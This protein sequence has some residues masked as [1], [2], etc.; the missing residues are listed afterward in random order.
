MPMV[1]T[2]PS[3]PTS[4]VPLAPMR[5]IASATSHVGSTV[6]NTAIASDS[7][8]ID[9]GTA[10]AAGG[11]VSANCASTNTVDASIAKAMNRVL[12]IR[13]IRSPAPTR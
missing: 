7:A 10:S 6:E 3:E 2:G 11:R 5:R 4:D 12:P 9:G 8:W 1:N 13:P